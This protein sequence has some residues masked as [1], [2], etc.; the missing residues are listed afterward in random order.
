[1]KRIQASFGPAGTNVPSIERDFSGTAIQEGEML[2]TDGISTTSENS[3]DLV[4]VRRF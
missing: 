1:M 2:L 4:T 3:L